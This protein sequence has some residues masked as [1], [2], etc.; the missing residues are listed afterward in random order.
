MTAL[1]SQF[2]E[3]SAQTVFRTNLHQLYADFW[4]SGTAPNRTQVG[5][6]VYQGIYNWANATP[7]GT[8]QSSPTAG[9]ALYLAKEQAD[10]TFAPTEECRPREWSPSFVFPDGGFVVDSNLKSAHLAS[11]FDCF[12]YSFPSLPTGRSLDVVVDWITTGPVTVQANGQSG[13]FAS[14]ADAQAV[15]FITDGT[16]QYA[17]GPAGFALVLR[18]VL[19]HAN[20]R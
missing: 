6:A 20:P 11:I 18:Y 3:V 1:L 19:N 15:G 16:Q 9:G 17:A 8:G 13:T 2:R 7:E 5:G 14:R 12:W 10:G 4:I